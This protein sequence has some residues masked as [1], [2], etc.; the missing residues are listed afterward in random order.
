MMRL[1]EPVVFHCE[2]WFYTFYQYAFFDLFKCSLAVVLYRR[3]FSYTLCLS[4]WMKM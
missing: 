3:D 2:T 1:A 4:F